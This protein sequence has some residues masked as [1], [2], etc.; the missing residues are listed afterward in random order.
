MSSSTEGSS[1]S[2]APLKRRREPEDDEAAVATQ[3]KKSKRR[4]P[5]KKGAG[6]MFEDFDVDNGLNKAIG[7][8]GSHLLS[9]FLAVQT[10]R[11]SGDLSTLEL[12]DMYLPGKLV[13]V[14]RRTYLSLP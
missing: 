12:Q 10:K 9:D 6:N 14:L 5:L 4:K 3:K 1:T 7:R 8:M 13:L 11:H 2:P